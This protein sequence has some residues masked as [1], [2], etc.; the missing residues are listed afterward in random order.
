VRGLLRAKVLLATSGQQWTVPIG[1]GFGR[2]FKVGDQPV[3]A[4]IAGYYNSSE[5]TEA[6]DLRPATE[7]EIRI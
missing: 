6:G 3:N 7:R 1:G 5:G 2:V 4:Q